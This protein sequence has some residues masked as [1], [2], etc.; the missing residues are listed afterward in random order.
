MSRTGNPT[1]TIESLEVNNWDD[2]RLA[3]FKLRQ[4]FEQQGFRPI[5]NIRIVKRGSGR[6]ALMMTIQLTCEGKR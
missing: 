2:L 6:L 4:D 5:G 3:T 1:R